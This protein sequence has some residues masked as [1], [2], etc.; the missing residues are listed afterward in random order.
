MTL[1]AAT[2]QKIFTGYYPRP[3]QE[4]LHAQ[5][6]R[7]NV[8]VCHRRFGK[9]MFA[10]NEMIDQGIRNTKRNPRYAYIA[11]T[12]GQA[13]RI[14]WD[15]L[16]DYTK[17]FPGVD[18]NEQDLRVDIPRPERDDKIRLTLLGAENPG[19]IKGIYLD[20]VILDEFAES[21]PT[22]WSQAVRPALSDRLGWAI[23]V[24][25]PRGENHF[26]D[27][28]TH[29]QKASSVDTWFWAIYKA[30]ETNILPKSELDLAKSEM[31]EEEYAQEYECSFTAANVGSYYG[32]LIGEAE[33]AKRITKISYDPA[34]Q[35]GTYWDL[36]I[37][38]SMAIWF[39]QQMHRNEYRVIDYLESSGRGLD[40][41]A[42][43]LKQK[44]YVYG[45]H[46]LPHDGA[47]RSLETGRTRQETL[48]DLGIKTRI[49]KKQNI[50]DGI[51]AV[52]MILPKCHF[53]EVKCARGIAALK[54]YQK[55]WDSKN[56]IFSDG[57][58]HNW[59]SNGADAFRTFAM[60]NSEINTR[61]DP[62]R[63]PRSSQGSWDIFNSKGE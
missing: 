48:R 61:Q 44:P 2:V 53:D 52:R 8:I 56:K 1:E 7:F 6:K 11:P 27:V 50:D 42:R 55:K 16:K 9:T 49:I 39:V 15:A 24:G 22:V 34:L 35:V 60:G 38:D 41:Y 19:S 30:S 28:L 14:A 12:Y 63:L 54:N 31:A 25:T 57:P 37:S 18:V 62:S 43:E 10:L 13:K 46:V 51:H 47:A 17:N 40:F 45:E 5:L 20:G 36:G 59:A 33:E 23:F 26:Y 58:L 4:H 29:A 21:D 32:K 3:H